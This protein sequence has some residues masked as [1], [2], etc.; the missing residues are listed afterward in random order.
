MTKIEI[1]LD[2]DDLYYIVIDGV[3]YPALSYEEIDF[4]HDQIFQ[5]RGSSNDERNAL[6]NP[7]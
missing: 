3:V 5:I 6:Q 7:D 1:R 4:L 2:V